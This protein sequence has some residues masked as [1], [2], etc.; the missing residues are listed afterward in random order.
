MSFPNWKQSNA[1]AKS[2]FETVIIVTFEE[3]S[4]DELSEDEQNLLETAFVDAYSAANAF[5]RHTCDF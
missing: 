5:N 1:A 2:K 4:S 3:H